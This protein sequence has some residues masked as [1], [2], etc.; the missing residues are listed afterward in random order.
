MGWTAWTRTTAALTSAERLPAKAGC[1]VSADQGLNWPKT[2]KTAHVRITPEPRCLPADH[3]DARA[4]TAQKMPFMS[5]FSLPLS[6]RLIFTF[7]YGKR[8]VHTPPSSLSWKRG[9]M[10]FGAALFLHLL[11]FKVDCFVT[12][13]YNPHDSKVLTH[14]F[15][16]LILLRLSAGWD[17]GS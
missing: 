2:R 11:C 17:G 3:T 14:S 13:F 10:H 16:E 9:Q 8:A 7:L 6:L 4:R 15:L 1:P 12:L 5:F